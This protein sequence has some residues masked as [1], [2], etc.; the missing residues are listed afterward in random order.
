M[1]NAVQPTRDRAALADGACLADQDQ[2]GRL[3]RV[4]NI[5]GI[6]QNASAHAENERAMPLQNRSESRFIALGHKAF[7]QVGIRRVT[8]KLAPNE[9]INSITV[10]ICLCA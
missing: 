9:R 10:P 5:L 4:V 1:G 6:A 8:P 7:Q 2:E 3:K